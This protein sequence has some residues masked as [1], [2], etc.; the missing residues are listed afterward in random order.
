MPFGPLSLT[1]QPLVVLALGFASSL[2][3]SLVFVPI[4]RRS[5]IQARLLDEP[6]GRKLHKQAVPRLGGVAIF[7]AFVGTLGLLGLLGQSP[8]TT[9]PGMLGLLA[10]STL[11]FLL[12]LLDDF[13]N[14][15]PYFKLAGQ[16]FAAS[17]AFGLGVAVS[18]LDLPWS[19]LLLLNAL[20]FPVTAVWLVGL[21]N[22]VNFIDGVDG[23]AGGVSA[24]AALTLM[25]VALFTQQPE[26]AL[27]AAM[28]G[29]ACLGF[30]V[31]NTHPARIFM[32]DSGALFLGF[33]LAS[34]AILGVLKTYTVVML[35]PV[36]VLAVPVAD[37]VY[38]TF[39]RLLQ[40][41]NPFKADANHLHHWL[42]KRGMHPRTIAWTFYCLCLVAGFA[43]A[44]YIQQ[45]WVY[46]ALTGGT[47][48]LMLIL[49]ALFRSRE[50]LSGEALPQEEVVAGAT[51]TGSTR[52]L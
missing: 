26:A 15:S 31:H 24:I 45:L 19:K 9:E 34:I 10:G 23:L 36:L 43:V 25:M 40:G 4:M 30:L 44:G 50:A 27:L 41:K 47:L 49:V 6:G 18:A 2:V 37:I 16:F 13:L 35:T 33:T 20:S 21:S 8:W 17:V 39:R 38:S 28:L 1:S 42:L 46:L 3:L 48:A 51:E 14:L 52:N 12:G 32:G 29:G 7:M 22:A 5:A 11:M